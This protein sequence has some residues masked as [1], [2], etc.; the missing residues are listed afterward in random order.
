MEFDGKRWAS[1][2]E[3]VIGEAVRLGIIDLYAAEA[4]AK[5]DPERL[6]RISSLFSVSRIF[7]IVRIAKGYL[8][9]KTGEFDA[10]PD[11][12]NVGNGVVNLRD[13]TLARTIPTLLFTKLCPTDYIPGATHADWTKALEG[14]ARRSRFVDWLQFRFGQSITGYPTPDD[15]LVFLK[16]GGENGKTTVVVA[17]QKSVGLDYV[18]T[19]PDRVLLANTG[20]HPT[21]L[22]TLRGARLAF[23][24]ELPDQHLNIKRLK[25]THGKGRCPRGTAARTAWSGS[26]RTRSSSPPTTCRASMSPSTPSGADWRWSCSR[27]AIASRMRR[28]RILAS[29]AAAMPGCA[30]GCASV[31]RGDTRRC[32]RG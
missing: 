4:K 14:V 15:V 24:E 9:V 32:W 21:E 1:V 13:G 17:I 12:L 11:L 22:M 7:A 18:V 3:P 30:S 2:A 6:K 23:M 16:G 31:G 10:H 27:T 29:T 25:D 20:D 28:S 8:W 19:L 26:R 5:V